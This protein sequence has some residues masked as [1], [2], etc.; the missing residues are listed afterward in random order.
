M[1]SNGAP[2]DGQTDEMSWPGSKADHQLVHR[3]FLFAHHLS[4]TKWTRWK[5]GIELETVSLSLSLSPIA[6]TFTS[7]TEGRRMY[8][9]LI[10]KKKRKKKRKEDPTEMKRRRRFA[11][12]SI[13]QKPA[14]L[15]ASLSFPVSL[16]SF[17]PA[18]ERLNTLS[19]TKCLNLSLF[20]RILSP[21][22]L[23]FFLCSFPLA[24]CLVL[25]ECVQVVAALQ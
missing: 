13:Y 6:L 7:S 4:K 19:I 21:L 3:H 22:S 17:T 2:P 18:K 5:S 23:S 1:H 25:F 24:R 9:H 14:T 12:S 8:T 16:L 15:A 20:N 11:V 10:K